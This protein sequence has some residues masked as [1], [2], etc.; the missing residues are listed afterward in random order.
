[1]AAQERGR[2][3]ERTNA[4]D[5]DGVNKKPGRELPQNNLSTPYKEVGNDGRW[6]ECGNKAKRIPVSESKKD[7]EKRRKKTVCGGWCVFSGVVLLFGGVG[8]G[9]GGRGCHGGGGR[10]GW[11]VGCG[12]H[13]EEKNCGEGRGDEG[14]RRGMGRRA[15]GGVRNQET[16]QEHGTTKTK[17]APGYGRMKVKGGQKGE[18]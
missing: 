5:R 9:V 12:E 17:K 15:L 3:K 2:R 1:M 11:V 16:N 18:R 14:H 6:F 10:G 8:W 7:L 4:T 13:W